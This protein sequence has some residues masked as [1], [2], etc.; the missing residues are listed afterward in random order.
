MSQTDFFR[1]RTQASA[2]PMLHIDPE[3]STWIF[4]AGAFGQSLARAMLI[5]G[6][7]VAGFVE[8]TPQSATRQ[9]LP[10]LNWASLAQQDSQA[11]LALG[12]FNRG[13]AYDRLLDIP[14]SA[15]FPAPCMPW[16]L[17]E[18]FGQALGWRFWLS[19]RQFLLDGIDR[20]A[21]VAQKL[22]DAESVQVLFRICAFRLGL[23]MGFASFLSLEKQ[24]FNALTLPPLQGKAITYVDCGAYIGDTHGELLDQP[25]ISCAQAFLLEPDPDNY[26]QLVRHAARSGA[27]AVCL[28]LAA[29][30][31]HGTLA[32]TTGQG[33][34]CAL[35]QG[36]E[37][38]ATESITVAA[39][40]QILPNTSVHLLKLDI[41]GAEAQALRGARHLIQRNRPILA[42]SLYHNPQDLWELP[43]LLFTLCPDYR[44]HIRQHGFNSFDTVLYAVPEPL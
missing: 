8:T 39:L 10:V 37:G 3:R 17:Y 13:I 43:E 36:M 9:G 7:A 21:S 15:G 18:Q 1:L 4:G 19:P 38:S 6:C 34:A 25:G 11:Q 28:P 20:I 41:E 12:I 22:A 5:Q 14:A 27:S 42:V 24:Y 32:F 29:A 2:Q 26:A 35:Q 31:S 23:D 44:F 33:E 30:D 16:T 40:D